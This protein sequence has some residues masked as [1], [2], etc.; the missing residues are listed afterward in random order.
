MTLSPIGTLKARSRSATLK[1]A[2]SRKGRLVRNMQFVGG[3]LTIVLVSACAG[4]G[5]S[6]AVTPNTLSAANTIG[7]AAS[8]DRFYLANP[9]DSAHSIAIFSESASGV[10]SPIGTIDTPNAAGTVTLDP[11]GNIFASFGG[12][13]IVEYPAGSSGAATPVR[14]ISGPA[15]HINLTYHHD[16]DVSANGTIAA[17]QQ[18]ITTV[19]P[20][21]EELDIYASTANGNAAP[22]RTIT[23]P[24]TKLAQGWPAIAPDGTVYVALSATNQILVFGPTANGNVAPSRIIQGSATGLNDPMDLTLLPNGNVVAMNQAGGLG[25]T[26]TEYAAN[27]SGNAAPVN[28]LTGV[29]DVGSISFDHAGNL[30]TFVCC[31]SATINEYA[32][33]ASGAA[34]PVRTIVP[35][36]IV[37][38]YDIAAF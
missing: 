23:G 13:S 21:P 3:L 8:A 22:V 36:G 24:N 20:A 15:T 19:C 34:T 11:A 1:A 6:G 14:R 32:A 10:A 28:T 16:F 2:V 26:I 38:A 31:P 18:T 12:N 9:N 30:W 37:A 33:H 27:A 17:V 25:G 7:N 29:G 5:G 4:G 35:N